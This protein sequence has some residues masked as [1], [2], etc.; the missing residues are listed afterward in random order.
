MLGC[1]NHPDRY[2]LFR[3]L[4][5]PCYMKE[6][7][8][9]NIE[10]YPKKQRIYTKAPVKYAEC[11]PDRVAKCRGLCGSCYG[12]YLSDSNPSIKERIKATNKRCRDNNKMRDPSGFSAKHRNRTLR[13]RYGIDQ[14]TYNALLE[15]QGGVCAICGITPK[16]PGRIRHALCVDHCHS[17]GAVR[18]LLCH[19]CNKDV[20]VVDRGNEYVEKLRAYINGHLV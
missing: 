10:S 18:G 2:V 14:S 20:S 19:G 4:C 1:P 3:G 9:G 5:K 15:R 13:G 8:S 16:P 17:T 7:R 6:W 11:H 12:K